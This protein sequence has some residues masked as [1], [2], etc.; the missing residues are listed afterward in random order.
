M[1][2]RS[3][4]VLVIFIVACIAFCLA[5][6]FGAMTGPIS[7]LPNE[8]DSGSVLDN[9][10][11]ITDSDNNYESYG[12]ENVHEYYND[13]SSQDSSQSTESNVETTTDDSSQQQ[14]DQSH[15]DS[16][17]KSD[18]EGGSSSGED[19]KKGSDSDIVTTRG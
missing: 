16:S 8:S 13:Y 18:E 9:L 17:D 1:S 5:S 7:I 12:D 2:S 11:A 3:A 15:Q 19:S 6:V 4:T 14:Q 10:S